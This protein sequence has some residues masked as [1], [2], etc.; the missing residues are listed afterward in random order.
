MG[1]GSGREWRM[2]WQESH[3]CPLRAPSVIPSSVVPRFLLLLTH[4]IMDALLQK[5]AIAFCL[6]FLSNPILPGHGAGRVCQAL[7]PTQRTC[8][9]AGNHADFDLTS[10]FVQICSW[11]K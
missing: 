8:A 3:Q 5:H 7:G 2:E 9:D 10:A 6:W 11:K 4:H 1:Q